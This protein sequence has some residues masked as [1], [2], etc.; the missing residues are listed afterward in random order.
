MADEASKYRFKKTQL[1]PA[2]SVYGILRAPIWLGQDPWIECGRNR[3]EVF[4][5]GH[6]CLFAH[7]LSIVRSLQSLLQRRYGVFDRVNIAHITNRLCFADNHD[8]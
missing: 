4:Y 8:L 3:S 5:P 7:T 1:K 2:Y 6:K